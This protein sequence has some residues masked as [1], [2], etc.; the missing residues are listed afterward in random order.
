MAVKAA[1]W[2]SGIGGALID[3]LFQWCRNNKVI[4]K[5][6]LRVRVDHHRAIRLYQRL[7][8]VREGLLRRDLCIGGVYHDHLAMGLVRQVDHPDRAEPEGRLGRGDEAGGELDVTRLSAPEA[9]I[10]V[11]EENDP[12]KLKAL[13]GTEKRRTVL[14][15]LRKRLREVEGGAG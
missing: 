9:M 15:A 14:D 2:G 10:K 6:N 13:L 11:S 8:F 7:G 1:H 12:D 4:T 3:A 5:I